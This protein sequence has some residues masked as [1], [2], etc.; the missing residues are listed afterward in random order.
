MKKILSDMMI[1][2]GLLTAGAAIN[3]C[4]NDDNIDEPAVKTYKV[5]I[6]ASK[7]SN[8]LTR[9][10]G[11]EDDAL[12][13]TWTAT[14]DKV[15]V[16]TPGKGSNDY[17]GEL[18]AQSSGVSTKLERTWTTATPPTVG[19]WLMLAY[20]K[21]QIT[22]AGQVG[23]LADISANFDYAEAIVEVVSGK[24]TG[25]DE[26]VTSEAVFDNLQ[27][28]VKFTLLNKADDLPLN[29]SSLTVRFKDS[30]DNDVLITSY[31]YATDARTYGE[32]TITPSGGAKSE[33]W[34][35]LSNDLSLF[36][37]EL[38]SVEPVTIIVTATVGDDT[39]SCTQADV[40]FRNSKYYAIT[41]RMTKQ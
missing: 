35:A 21:T 24:G 29:A 31:D 16:Y 23:T 7:N 28:V 34:A 14:T 8:G 15:K 38:D 13:A 12:V 30:S 39:Y 32:V 22:Y 19:D 33:I 26:I 36:C 1:L 37:S 20:P 4:S 27:S 6:N 18:T 5:K 40:E 10:I 17:V 11:F 9:A 25:T 3:A 41:V 2:A